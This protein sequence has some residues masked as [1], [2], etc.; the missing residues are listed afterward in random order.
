M[1]RY[2]PAPAY[3]FAIRPFFG[4]DFEISWT[5]DRYYTGSRLRHPQSRSRIT[6]RKGAERFCR[7]HDLEMPGVEK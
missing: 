3:D 4:G 1:S 2:R 6:N 7:K 5:Y